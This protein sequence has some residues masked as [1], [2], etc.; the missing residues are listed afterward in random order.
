M[1]DILK[2]KHRDHD[3]W[4]LKAICKLRWLP[5]SPENGTGIFTAV[6]DVKGLCLSMDRWAI[7]SAYKRKLKKS[8]E[9]GMSSGTSH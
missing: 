1:Y 3:W 2:D 4:F 5:A 9:E 7:P 6:I 8:Y